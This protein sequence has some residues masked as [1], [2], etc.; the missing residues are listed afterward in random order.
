MIL[1]KFRYYSLFWLDS[2]L[3]RFV[4]AIPYKIAFIILQKRLK[5]LADVNIWY[6]NSFKKGNYVFGISDLD[7]TILMSQK[8]YRESSSEIL[9]ILSSHKKIFPFLGESNFYFYELINLESACLNDFESKRDPILLFMIASKFENENQVEKI[10]FL[11]RALSSDKEKLTNFPLIRQSK[12][13]AHLK[14]LGIEIPK[15]VTKDFIIDTIIDLF[16]LPKEQH[17]ELRKIMAIS[18]STEIKD[19]DIYHIQLPY[20]WKYIFPHKFIWE[21]THLNDDFSLIKNTIIEKI[22][23]R[24]L[25]WENWGI[26]SQ[27]P[28]LRKNNDI[29]AHLNRQSKLALALGDKL[30]YERFKI[31][32][33]F[34]E[35]LK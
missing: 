21:E 22:C 6:R 34:A 18:S 2:L 27:L 10:V 19:H 9:H 14:D 7:I 32:I 33:S 30:T 17:P 26:M 8:N 23:L 35:K 25:N 31:V 3:P 13:K 20:L 29:I 24:Q 5:H 1:K 15:Q 16:D 28:F 11:L 12:W 4:A